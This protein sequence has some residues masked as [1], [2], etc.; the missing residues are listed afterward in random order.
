MFVH[1]PWNETSND[2]NGG[3]RR[4]T[5][6]LRPTAKRARK[7]ANFL[8]LA[9]NSTIRLLRLTGRRAGRFFSALGGTA[10]IIPRR[11]ENEK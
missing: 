1:G 2:T 4:F 5:R 7:V 3:R 8:L 10:E 6:R 9:C 11:Y